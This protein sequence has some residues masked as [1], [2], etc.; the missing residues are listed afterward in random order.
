MENYPKNA[1]RDK[2]TKLLNFLLFRKKMDYT[3][4][5]REEIMNIITIND[6]EALI[7]QYIRD[8]SLSRFTRANYKNSI[9]RFIEYCRGRDIDAPDSEHFGEFKAYR[10]SK[11]DYPSFSGIHS[12]YD[13]VEFRGLGK[14][15]TLEHRSRVEGRNATRHSFK[16][17]P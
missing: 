17:V 16:R 11:T 8:S 6:L 7:P 2:T 12:I 3:D 15:I 4:E 9:Y 5:R 1:R 13:Y 10:L 14:N